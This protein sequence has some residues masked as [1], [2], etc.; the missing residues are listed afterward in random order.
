MSLLRKKNN[1]E[2]VTLPDFKL[3]LKAN[4]SCPALT[5]GPMEQNAEPREK[6]TRY[7][8]SIS[9]NGARTVPST[10]AAGETGQP[11]AKGRNGT[12]FPHQTQKA[13]QNGLKS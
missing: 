10:G 1:D 2:G 13:S 7:G 4:Q 3:Y 6:F 9:D 8:Q 5:R 11:R 12:T